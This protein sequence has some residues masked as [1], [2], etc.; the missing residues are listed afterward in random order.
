[1]GG[2]REAKPAGEG[3]TLHWGRNGGEVI[4]METHAWIGRA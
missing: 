4:A 1:M 3:A 2:G